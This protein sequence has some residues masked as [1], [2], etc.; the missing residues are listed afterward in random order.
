MS[1]K[2]QRIDTEK[3]AKQIYEDALKGPLDPPAGINLGDGVRPFWDKLVMAK[4][5]RAWTEP[6]LL[7]LVELA[8]NLYRTEKLSLEILNEPEVFEMESGPKVNPKSK[9][10]DE[11]VK[12]AR[13][14]MVMLQ[15]HPEATQ[16]KSGMQVKQNK[17]AAAASESVNATKDEDLLARPMAH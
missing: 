16:G 7:M 1:T 11:L 15:I 5:R 12:R 8:R 6:D 2:R 13:L 17:A 4:A 9:L 10:I 14:I 3:G